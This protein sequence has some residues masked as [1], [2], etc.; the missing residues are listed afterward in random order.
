MVALAIIF[1]V[2]LGLTDAGL[3]V[4]EYNIRNT[5]RDEGVS[6]AESEMAA[7]RNIPFAA[8]TVGVTARPVVA[9]RI[10][11]L[12]VNYTPSWT[13]TTLNADNLQVVVNVGWNRRGIAYSHQATT[14][15]RNR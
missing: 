14:I 1:I 11:G 12:T 5:I 10:R 13:I 3:L 8:L 2:F 9:Q 15:V 7:M 4:V 6:V